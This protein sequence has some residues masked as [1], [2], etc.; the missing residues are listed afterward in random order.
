M[1]RKAEFSLDRNALEK[2]GLEYQDHLKSVYL[3][4]LKLIEYFL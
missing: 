3:P 4:F 2:D 1:K